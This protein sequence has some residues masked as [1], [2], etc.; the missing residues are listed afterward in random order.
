MKW[1]QATGIKGAGVGRRPP[2]SGPSSRG[3][4][5]PDAGISGGWAGEDDYSVGTS[6]QGPMLGTGV[7]GAR[8]RR[9]EL[10]GH[11]AGEGRSWRWLEGHRAGRG[12][13]TDEGRR[14]HSA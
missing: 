12:A 6:K 3:V 7:L 14:G 8:C 4:T 5:V 10:W 9:P 1:A 11:Q 2:T 13:R